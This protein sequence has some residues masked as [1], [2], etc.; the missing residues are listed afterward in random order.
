MSQLN[1]IV[2]AEAAKLTILVALADEPSRTS[3][4]QL[5]QGYID[6]QSG[7]AVSRIFVR[8]RMLE[9]EELKAVKI[10]K[11]GELLI[12][13]ITLVGVEHVEGRSVIKGIQRPQAV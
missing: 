12:A 3:N 5:L 4:E 1:D 7:R 9:L 13:S 10:K 8:E 6:L 2:A 11:A